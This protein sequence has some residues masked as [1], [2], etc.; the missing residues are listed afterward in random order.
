MKANILK[1]GEKISKKSDKAMQGIVNST[2]KFGKSIK[3][4]ARIKQRLRITK[5]KFSKRMRERR[6]RREE[7]LQ[8]ERTE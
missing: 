7:E 8:L 2:K 1:L 6:K 5:K 3:K 4:N